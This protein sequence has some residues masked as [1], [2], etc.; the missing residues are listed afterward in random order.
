MDRAPQLAAID[1]GSNSFRLEICRVEQGHL[2]RKEYLKDTVR[3]G[4]GL[5]ERAQLDDASMQ[6]GWASLA[7]FAERLR[8]AGLDA[9]Y[10]AGEGS[11]KSQM[12]KADASGAEYAVIVGETELAARAAA[13]KPLRAPDSS[14]GGGEQRIVPLDR[15]ADE[16]VEALTRADSP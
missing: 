4:A 2:V 1:L 13:L 12:K 8:G 6:R 9:M 15:L 11:L 5:D 3:L 16:V 14:N 7:R 10:H